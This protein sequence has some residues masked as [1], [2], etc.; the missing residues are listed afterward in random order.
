MLNI[1]VPTVPLLSI[2]QSPS[3]VAASAEWT[4]PTIEGPFT[5]G[6]RWHQHS[7]HLEIFQVLT[8]SPAE[9][10]GLNVGQ[11][12]IYLNGLSIGAPG[13]PDVSQLADSDFPKQA[14]IAVENVDG[15]LRR[16]TLRSRGISEIVAATSHF[17]VPEGGV[18]ANLITSPVPLALK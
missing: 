18:S 7:D 13:G 6:L 11:K 15:T 12:I 8:G 1:K 3:V 4:A 5:F 17:A 2:M 10:A 14:E 9:V 16:I